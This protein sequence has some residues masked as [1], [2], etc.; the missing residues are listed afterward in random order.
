MKLV[1]YTLPVYYA[2]ALVNG[3]YS[4]MSDEEETEL[5][6]FLK[7]KVE[8]YGAFYCVQADVEDV[9]F[10]WSNDMNNLGADCC[11]FHFDIDK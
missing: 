2:S 8:Q 7:E 11:T 10:R 3:D 5:N 4:G 1:E 6:N 9:S